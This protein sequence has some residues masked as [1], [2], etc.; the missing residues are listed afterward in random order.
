[1][2]IGYMKYDGEEVV[3]AILMDEFSVG[4]ENIN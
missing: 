4:K 3:Q 2:T 1:M